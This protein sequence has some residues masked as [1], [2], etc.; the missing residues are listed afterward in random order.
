MTRNRF[1]KRVVSKR[2]TVMYYI[3]DG[4]WFGR[5]NRVE[6]ELGLATGKYSE[7]V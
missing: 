6:A 1:I 3:G 4:I 7:W 5:I 2:G